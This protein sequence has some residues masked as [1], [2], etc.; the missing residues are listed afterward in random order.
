MG[1]ESGSTR[2]LKY[3]KGESVTPQQGLNAVAFLADAGIHTNAAFIIGSPIE[4][5]EEVM[6]TLAFIKKSKLS[7]FLTYVMTP[8]PG[9]PIWDYA[10]KRGLVSCDMD[11]EKLAIDF[12]DSQEERVLVSEKLTRDEI[13]GLY[14]LFRK[15]EKKK[16]NAVRL[17]KIIS[18]PSIVMKRLFGKRI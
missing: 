4:T 2:I 12:T 10:L 18:V 8:Y 6:E 1:L 16:L 3:L 17:K 15:E 14:E 11:F 13:Y 9:T 7:S 5:R